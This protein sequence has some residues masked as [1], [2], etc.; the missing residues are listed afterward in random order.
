M[1]N[2]SDQGQ[3]GKHR[4]GSALVRMIRQWDA[5]G[6]FRIILTYGVSGVGKSSYCWKILQE[7]YP[8]EA[9]IKYDPSDEIPE[10]LWDKDKGPY[11]P[12]DVRKYLLFSPVEM[13]AFSRY[14]RKHNLKVPCM[15]VDDAG[16]HFSSDNYYDPVVQAAGKYMQVARSNVTTF[17]FTSTKLSNVVA[18]IRSGDVMNCRISPYKG[19]LRWARGYRQSIDAIGRTRIRAL[20][21][22]SFNKL[23]DNDLFA[24]YSRVRN[25]YT[26]SATDL[27]EKALQEKVDL[28]AW[29]KKKYGR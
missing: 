25:S 2:T 18:S 28:E 9:K 8:E 27:M 5:D 4:G 15:L 19:D 14:A 24:W 11:Y 6:F 22:D 26:D 12:N 17:M 21:E 20:W 7:L 16:L 10:Q 3:K 1:S 29:R 13:L 23:I